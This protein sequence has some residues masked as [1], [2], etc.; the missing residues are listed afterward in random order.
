MWYKAVISFVLAA[1][2]FC[3]PG[4]VHHTDSDFP[5]PLVPMFTMHG[6]TSFNK[7]E[8]GWIEEAAGIWSKQT[9]GLAN[10]K[11]VWDYV[12][13]ESEDDERKDD[14]TVVKH[15]SYEPAIVAT[16]C[17]ISEEAGLP[18]GVCVPMLMA[19][20]WPSGGIH[21][22]AGA[23]VS[24]NFIPDRYDGKDRWISVAI[25]E[26]GHV[27]GLPHSSFKQAVMWPSNDPAK[28]CLKQPDLQAFCQANVCEGHVMH[29]CK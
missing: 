10:I 11:F 23:A 6:D 18:P 3:A 25:H 16:D 28:T 29:P 8:R 4:C 27:F 14:Y 13:G 5:A 9:D 22:T 7:E 2:A 24:L 21:N 12:P 15:T 26:M 19:W 17:D 20:V 1:L